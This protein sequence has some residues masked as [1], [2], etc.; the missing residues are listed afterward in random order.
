[1][2]SLWKQV[3]WKLRRHANDGVRKLTS[4]IRTPG[5][6][7]KSEMRKFYLSK[8]KEIQHAKKVT[9][10]KSDTTRTVNKKREGML[11][12]EEMK[13][14]LFTLI[15]SPQY[16]E[17]LSLALLKINKKLLSQNRFSEIINNESI[18]WRDINGRKMECARQ[19]RSRSK[20][21]LFRSSNRD[22]FECL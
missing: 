7:S 15:T 17:R 16:Q 2:H 11:L 10:K 12:L 14:K 4:K 9:S 13:R 5:T 8:Y 20:R 19:L 1:M 21:K 3:Y 6:Q 18:T 22:K